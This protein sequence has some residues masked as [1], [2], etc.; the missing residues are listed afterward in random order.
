VPDTKAESRKQS[1]YFP[2]E[3][4]EEIAAEARRLDRSMSWV[5]Q[6]AWKL[7]RR[8][9]AE[10][11]PAAHRFMPRAKPAAPTATPAEL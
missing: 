2:A 8:A 10:L 11:K 4:L 1:F 5:V 6:R 7:A 3:M 9:I